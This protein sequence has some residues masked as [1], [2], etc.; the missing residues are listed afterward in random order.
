MLP[1]LPGRP[2]CFDEILNTWL[3]DYMILGPFHKIKCPV[4]NC[5]RINVPADCLQ[6]LLAESE[7]GRW[8]IGD[9][10]ATGQRLC[11]WGYLKSDWSVTGRR[12]IIHDRSATGCQ[13]IG[14]DKKNLEKLVWSV[15]NHGDWSAISYL[16]IM[17]GSDRCNNF[18][19]LCCR[20]I[21]SRFILIF[22]FGTLAYTCPIAFLAV[23]LLI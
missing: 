15:I 4:H 17:C 9:G 10:L 2:S 20:F 11:I 14:G 12:P 8:P 5:I 23:R 19:G 13:P 6:I 7:T 1:S 18:N 22:V 21:Y 16:S 3:I